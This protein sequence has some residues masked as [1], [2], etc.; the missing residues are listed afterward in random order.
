MGR[1]WP[2]NKFPLGFPSRPVAGLQAPDPPLQVLANRRHVANS[3]EAHAPA[4]AA[5]QHLAHCVVHS[6]MCLCHHKHATPS[7]PLLLLLPFLPRLRLL[8]SLLWLL[9]A[10]MVSWG[11]LLSPPPLKPQAHQLSDCVCLHKNEQRGQCK[12]DAR[13]RPQVSLPLAH[14]SPCHRPFKF[15]F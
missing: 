8:T 5:C 12:S 6:C 4:L 11:P 14:Q 10:S 2:R 1:L 13:C 9:L 3:D 15:T 7:W